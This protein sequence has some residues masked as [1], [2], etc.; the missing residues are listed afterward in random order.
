VGFIDRAENG[1]SN[2]RACRPFAAQQLLKV[3]G[4]DVRN[5]GNVAVAFNELVI[6]GN[7]QE[8]D[9]RTAVDRS[10]TTGDRAQ[11]ADELC[12]ADHDLCL[13]LHERFYLHRSVVTPDP[14]NPEVVV[15]LHGAVD[16]NPATAR[17]VPSRE[18]AA[19]GIDI[20]PLQEFGCSMRRARSASS[21]LCPRR[22]TRPRSDPDEV[23]AWST[24]PEHPSRT[25]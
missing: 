22:A 7:G 17:A 2:G 9:A 21:L 25:R 23:S 20:A 24:A 13:E 12:P 18:L 14:E 1:S 15:T 11:R 4:L 10:S 6:W 16:P 19:A 8:I 5:S 3:T